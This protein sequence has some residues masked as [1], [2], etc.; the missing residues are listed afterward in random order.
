MA[1]FNGKVWRV[2]SICRKIRLASALP[3]RAG[4]APRCTMAYG[5][6]RAVTRDTANIDEM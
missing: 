6:G 4:I 3:P 5:A 1:R 2:R